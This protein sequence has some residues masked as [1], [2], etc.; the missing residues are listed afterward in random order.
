MSTTE[1]KKKTV[2][3]FGTYDLLHIGHVNVLLRSRALGDRL[4]VGVSSD[5]FNFSRNKNI[6]FIMRM[7]E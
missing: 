1:E 5:A 2:I 7:I 4:V 3:T 6:L